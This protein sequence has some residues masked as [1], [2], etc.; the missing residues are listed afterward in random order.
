MGEC[1]L[2]AGDWV[3]WS[4][5]LTLGVVG[6]GCGRDAI[7]LRVLV[8]ECG[9]LT[10]GISVLLG[11]L[12]LRSVWEGGSGVEGSVWIGK[13]FWRAAATSSIL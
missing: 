3:G 11:V 8:V 7:R 4:V 1:M 9:V 5:I 12:E 10:A 2:V 13:F 6:A